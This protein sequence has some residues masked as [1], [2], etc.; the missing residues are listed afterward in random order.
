MKRKYYKPNNQVFFAVR[1]SGYAMALPFVNGAM[2]QLFLA[3]RGV[4]SERIGLLMSVL[5]VVNLLTTF[6]LSDLAERCQNPLQKS[7]RILLFHLVTFPAMMLTLLIPGVNTNQLFWMVLVVTC[8]QVVLFACKVIYEYKLAYQIVE[9]HKYGNMLALSGVCSGIAAFL[10]S[11]ISAALIDQSEGIVPYFLIM[12]ITE[13]SFLVAYLGG[14]KMFPINAVFCGKV[15]TN[16]NW[17]QVVSV[18][19]SPVFL[20]FVVPNILRGITMGG[21]GCIAL[22]ALSMGYSESFTATISVVCAVSSILGS[23]IFG[24]LERR[25][26]TTRIGLIGSA[27]LCLLIFLPSNN[28]TMFLVIYT[29]AYLGRIIVD[30]SVPVLVFKMIDPDVAGIYNAWRSILLSLSAAGTSYLVGVLVE[31]VH[32]LVL[33]IPFALAYL[34]CMIWYS[35][36]FKNFVGEK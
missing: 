22:V 34:I 5:H 11:I 1:E 17:K 32:P 27:L 28:G 15:I 19:C 13:F 21:T 23:F 29:V 31:H 33:L 35:V 9:T 25:Y 8:S 18:V 16:R 12:L 26:R 3:N 10:I 6:F 14:R 20:H 30:Q 2:V 24:L 4:P 7:D 36:F